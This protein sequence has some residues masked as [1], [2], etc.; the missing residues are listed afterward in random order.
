M[1]KKQRKTEKNKVNTASEDINELAQYTDQN[2]SQQQSEVTTNKSSKDGYDY[3][4]VFRLIALLFIHS[5]GIMIVIA[6]LIFFLF[7]I[8]SK[9]IFVAVDAQANSV[10]IT[11]NSEIPELVLEKGLVETRTL[12]LKGQADQ[13]V[14]FFL[15]GKA[16]TVESQDKSSSAEEVISD[17]YR[18]EM[19]PTHQSNAVR[20]HPDDFFTAKSSDSN[21]S[22]L[23]CR[24]NSYF[25]NSVE[26]HTSDMT[27]RNA[28]DM[29]FSIESDSVLDI[30]THDC[31][32]KILSD[33]GQVLKVYDGDLSYNIT[34]P[35]TLFLD[36][37]CSDCTIENARSISAKINDVK[38]ISLF[39]NGQVSVSYSADSKEYNLE[40]QPVSLCSNNSNYTIE[41]SQNKD[42]EQTAFS[43]SGYGVVNKASLANVPLMPSPSAWFRENIF[44]LPA[45]IIT[46]V[47][48]SVKLIE[49]TKKK[50]TDEN[51]KDKDIRKAN[52]DEE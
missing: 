40:K 12:S 36:V 16:V 30:S 28:Y 8:S 21:D 11:D 1:K 3:R 39:G 37:C 33:D 24:F 14:V 23:R 26:F 46:I 45:S 44:L 17:A 4:S 35:H 32:I 5:F 48:G 51:K 6:A 2:G 49:L 29:F 27:I 52:Q 20:I 31:Q 18:I 25:C 41:I 42:S 50:E 13:P 43:V 10:E 34:I 38:N 7:A 22:Y 15:F 9:E 47:L 19:I